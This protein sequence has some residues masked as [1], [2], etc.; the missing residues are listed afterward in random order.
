VTV[1]SFILDPVSFTLGFLL[2]YFYY[3]WDIPL[4]LFDV[5]DA[6]L[7]P[8]AVFFGVVPTYELIAQVY[9]YPLVGSG[10]PRT[11]PLGSQTI[12]GYQPLRLYDLVK[13][14]YVLQRLVLSGLWQGC[15][16]VG[17]LVVVEG[18][19]TNDPDQCGDA[20]ITIGRLV[21]CWSRHSWFRWMLILKWDVGWFFGE[22][23]RQFIY[24]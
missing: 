10:H 20:D 1:L 11:Y 7:Y 4:Y 6:R 15:P 14:T 13:A 17:F 21:G 22:R 3:C 2:G 5:V 23:E 9:I 18:G 16:I 19:F 12:S 24:Q 8:L